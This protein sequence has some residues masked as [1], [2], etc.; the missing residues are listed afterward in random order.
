MRFRHHF[1]LHFFPKAD[2]GKHQN[3][4]TVQVFKVQ[5][6]CIG[7]RV[8]GRQGKVKLLAFKR[9]AAKRAFFCRAGQDHQLVSAVF[10]ALQQCAGLFHFGNQRLLRVKAR[11]Q[12]RQIPQ[13]RRRARPKRN[14]A[15][16]AVKRL[17]LFGHVVCLF[18]HTACVFHGNFSVFIQGDLVLFAVKQGDLQR[19]L[20]FLNGA[21]QRRL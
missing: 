9:R 15:A 1:L 13:R 5:A 14:G 18:Q 3:R 4:L 8:L 7:Q 12:R 21:A 10:H 17:Q 11:H 20:Q 19:G 16:A 6:L 2:L